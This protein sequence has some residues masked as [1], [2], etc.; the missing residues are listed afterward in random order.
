[1]AAIKI[2]QLD[3]LTSLRF[4]AAMAILVHHC[5]G[6]FWTAAELG[7][8][9]VGVSFFFVLSGFI[10]TYVYHDMQNTKT[11]ILR[12]YALRITRIWPLH[13]ACL[14]LTILFIPLPGQFSLG[15]LA[16]NFFLIHAWIPYDQY[17]FSY[18]YVSWSIS[19]ELFFY[20]VFPLII[21]HLR[22]WL[23]VSLLLSLLSVVAL[24]IFSIDADL[25]P[26]DPTQNDMSSTGL[27]YVNPLARSFEF[28]L[29]IA[30]CVVFLKPDEKNASR[31]KWTWLEVGIIVIFVLGYR[32][33]ISSFAPLVHWLLLTI[34]ATDIP[35]ASLHHGAGTLGDISPGAEMFIEEWANHVGMTPFAVMLIYVMARQRGAISHA[36]SKT[37]LIFLGEISFA[38]YLVHQIV[39]RYF[40]QHWLLTTAMPKLEW[41]GIFVSCVLLAA[42]ALHLFIENPSREWMIKMLKKRQGIGTQS[43]S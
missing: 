30:T 36:L 33:F 34:G 19:T 37:W 3:A 9:D 22:K 5:N 13:V 15:V 40:Q 27:L 32:Y 41:F 14:L 25:L 10:L 28:I 42:T 20:L 18:N 23:S 31:K 38:L 11:A 29:G 17:F 39:L 26:W 16:A 21:L 43:I 4:F 6:V 2:K 12:F 24:T 35:M 7:P 8:I 1:M